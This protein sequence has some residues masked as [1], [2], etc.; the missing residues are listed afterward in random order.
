M[1]I[2]EFGEVFIAAAGKTIF[3]KAEIA[4]A[5]FVGLGGVEI[6]QGDVF[7]FELFGESDATGGEGGVFES[8]DAADAPGVIGDGLDEV[9]FDEAFGSELLEMSIDEGLV[10]G[11]VFGGEQDGAAAGEAGFHGVLRRGG[12]AGF[13]FGTRWIGGRWL[14]WQRVGFRRFAERRGW[15]RGFA[16]RQRRRVV[17]G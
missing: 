8:G 14:G 13:G 5:L 9:E 7:V 17:V 3:L 2:V 11:G 10:F 16:R 6:E 12:A 1:E 15:V 4:E